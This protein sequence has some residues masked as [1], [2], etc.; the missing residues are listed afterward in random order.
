MSK[1]Y[2]RTSG[3]EVTDINGTSECV[4]TYYGCAYL[5]NNWLWGN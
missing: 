1:L 3:K 4:N 5:R 2:L